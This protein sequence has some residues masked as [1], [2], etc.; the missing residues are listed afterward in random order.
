[1]TDRE[2][3]QEAKR[4]CRET[5]FGYRIRPR[6]PRWNRI[7]L[8]L[9]S[10]GAPPVPPPPPPAPPPASRYAPRA[11]NT[12]TN[13]SDAR[14]CMDSRWGVVRD[15]AGFRDAMGVAYDEGGRDLGGRTKTIVPELKPANEMD[16]RDVCDPYVGPTGVAIGGDAGYPPGSFQR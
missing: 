6:S 15:G 7:M 12:G 16:S 10:I 5:T 1:M 11:Y 13:L 9:E 3:A 8:L 4:L 2:A 14:F